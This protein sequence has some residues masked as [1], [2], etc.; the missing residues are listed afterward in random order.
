MIASKKPRPKNM[1]KPTTH[2]P[3][4]KPNQLQKNN[5]PKKPKH[6]NPSNPRKKANS[7]PRKPAGKPE[8]SQRKPNRSR[9]QNPHIHRNR[10]TK[11]R[12]MSRLSTL[13][14]TR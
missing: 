1:S 8:K 5:H 14:T 11:R 7:P 13:T 10:K 6:P 2:L 9:C 12:R 4:R 3:K